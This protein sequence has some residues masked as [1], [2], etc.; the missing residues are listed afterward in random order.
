M[1]IG[2]ED[3]GFRAFEGGAIPN[4]SCFSSGLSSHVNNLSNFTLNELT[5]D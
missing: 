3:V 2:Q 5:D 4:F 1:N